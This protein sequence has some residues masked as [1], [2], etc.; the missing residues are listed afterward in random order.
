VYQMQSHALARKSEH[1]LT[2]SKQ[3]QDASSQ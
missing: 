1:Y 3:L 2:L